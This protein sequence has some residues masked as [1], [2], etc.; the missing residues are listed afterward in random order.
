MSPIQRFQ[1]DTRDKMTLKDDHRF[2]VIT[3]IKDL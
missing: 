1:V 2:S 3:I